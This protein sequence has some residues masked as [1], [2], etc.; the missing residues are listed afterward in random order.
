M[1]EAIPPRDPIVP[2]SPEISGYSLHHLSPVVP[3]QS[4]FSYRSGN[5]YNLKGPNDRD[6]EVAKYEIGSFN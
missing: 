4:F 5:F 3:W 2:Q 6:P 1:R